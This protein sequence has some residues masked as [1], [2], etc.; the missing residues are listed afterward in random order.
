VVEIQGYIATLILAVI[1]LI[2]YCIY[3]YGRYRGYE[4]AREYYLDRERRL[5]VNL[6]SPLEQTNVQMDSKDVPTSEYRGA[7]RADEQ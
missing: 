6:N 2:Y 4:Q 3:H 1:I 5:G 7:D